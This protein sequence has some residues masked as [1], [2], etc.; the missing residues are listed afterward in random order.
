MSNSGTRSCLPGDGARA[1]LARGVSPRTMERVFD[2]IVADLHAEWAHAPSR[3]AALR[4]Y[5]SAH[6]AISRAVGALLLLRTS[7]ALGES[8]LRFG[9]HIAMAA[10]LTFALFFVLAS[11]SSP[12]ANTPRPR[13]EPE[14][15]DFV[16]SPPGESTPGDTP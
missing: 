16:R 8:T 7:R 3:P 10:A 9:L 11:I 12:D 14:L 4:A 2:P 15:Q 1:L 13:P 6:L 5:A